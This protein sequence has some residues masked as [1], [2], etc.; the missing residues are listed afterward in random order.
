MAFCRSLSAAFCGALLL[1][2][3]P[4]LGQL[5]GDPNKGT[6]D[7]SPLDNLPPY[8]RLVTKSGARPDWSPDGKRL[9]FF[10]HVPLGD[11][12]EVEIATGAIRQLT[13]GFNHMGFTRAYY[14]ANG[15]VLLCGPTSGRPTTDRPEAGRFTGMMSVFRAPF[16]RKPQSLGIPCWEG[17]VTA[18]NSLRIAWNR[19]E[20]DYTDPNI[21]NRILN[22]V[23]E[24]WTGELRY[25]GDRVTLVNIQLAMERAAISPFSVLEAQ[26]FRPGTNE[27]IFTAYAHVGGEVMGIDFQLDRCTRIQKVPSTKRRKGSRQTALGCSSSATSIALRHQARW[28]SGCC[29]SMVPQLGIASHIS[30]DT[31][32]DGTRR[33]LP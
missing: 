15:D 10:D 32:A 1:V 5:I 21:V 13:V 23:S 16:D 2:T 25:D 33:T 7:G 6:L 3:A 18:N 30:T 9:L 14:L 17:M 27:L 29:H 24:I 31:A 11:V 28:T 19:S 22:A 12:F 26:D 20:V 8:I 4:A